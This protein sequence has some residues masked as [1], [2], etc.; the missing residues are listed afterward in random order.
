MINIWNAL[1]WG[2]DNEI[3]VSNNSNIMQCMRIFKAIITLL[4]SRILWKWNLINLYIT[5]LQQYIIP[6]PLHRYFWRVFKFLA[7]LGKRNICFDF[8]ENKFIRTKISKNRQKY[9]RPKGVRR[10]W[11]CLP[12]LLCHIWSKRNNWNGIIELISNKSQTNNCF[13]NS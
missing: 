11:V 1:F 3:A 13:E 9:Y 7:I 8:R 12:L 5:Q 4:T 2:L 6:P 10:W